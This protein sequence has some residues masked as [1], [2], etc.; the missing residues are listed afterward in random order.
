MSTS[1]GRA[2]GEGERNSTDFEL[3]MEPDTELDLRTV[4]SQPELKPR[5][6]LLTPPK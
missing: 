1:G 4:R 3:S 2:E 5:V 6:G